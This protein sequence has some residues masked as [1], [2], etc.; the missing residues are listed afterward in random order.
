MTGRKFL[1]GLILF[2]TSLNSALFSQ[3]TDIVS[4]EKKD[5]VIAVVL[6]GG[7]ALGFAHVGALK[8]L[9]EEGIHPDIVIGT[10][11]GSIVGGLY[12]AG[13]TAREIEDI[14]NE[15]NWNETMTDSFVRSDLSFERKKM[16][17]DY[18][19]SLEMFTENETSNAGFSHAQHVVE[20]LDKLFVPYSYELDFDTLPIRFRAVAT[21]LQTGDVVVYQ[22]G[23]LKTVIRASM[24]V[25]AIFTPVKYKGRYVVDG[26]VTENL[27][28]A[29]AKEMGADIIIAVSL[30]S[31]KNSLE[32]L[33]TISEI[34]EQAL[35]IRTIEKLNQS[36][37]LADLIISPDLTGYTMADFEKSAPL[38]QLGYEAASEMREDID[39]IKKLQGDYH[40]PI[41]REYENINLTIH[42]ISID[43]GGSGGSVNSAEL[44]KESIKAELGTETTIVDLQNYLYGLYDTGEYTHVWYQLIPDNNGGFTLM[45]DAP[46]QS[47]I[48]DLFSASLDFSG[49]M[50]ESS[51][52]DFILKTDYQRWFGENLNSSIALKVW[53]SEYPSAQFSFINKAF[54]GNLLLSANV[55]AKQTSQYF[56]EDDTVESIYSLNRAG[57]SFYVSLPLWKFIEFSVGSNGEYAGID[58]RSG[59]NKYDEEYTFRFGLENKIS[60]DTLNRIITPQ[61]GLRAIAM[62]D[63]AVDIDGKP[64]LESKIAA[65][66][67]FPLFDGFILN[68]RAEFQSLIRGELNPVELPTLG[69]AM[70]FHGYYLQELRAD[71]VSMIGLNIRKRIFSFPMVLGKEVY[72]QLAVNGAETRNRELFD[73]AEE[74]EFYF[75]GSVG[76]IGNSVLGEI[77]LN[78]GMNKDGRFSTYLGL[79]KS[80]SFYNRH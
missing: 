73:E 74:R 1:T 23:D 72:L 70:I 48:E 49:Q 40:Q 28:T 44:M 27:P 2:I 5:P 59:V 38:M 39:K 14:V 75:G 50:I 33:D 19:L 63:G 79:S 20:L 67:Y 58:F 11:M 16:D 7:G 43:S 3:N 4:I 30:F 52:A 37:D 64:R 22:E 51:I 56:F 46:G 13:Y 55:Y 78:F 29:I 31:I 8:V 18:V 21:D 6:A 80:T 32:E 57:A 62:L 65:E 60:V 61:K 35:Q 9:E 53:L 71:N 76:I 15:T 24:S 26:G 68:P 42:N 54:N 17:S 77:Q 34:T 47:Q 12:S 66:I 69:S 10:S 45:V 36:L 25:P 41:P